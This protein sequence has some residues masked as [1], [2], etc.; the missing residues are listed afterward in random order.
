MDSEG[1]PLDNLAQD[2]LKLVQSL[3][4]KYTKMSEIMAAGPDKKVSQAI[5]GAIERANKRWEFERK[6][7]KKL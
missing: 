7:I 6:I 3:G 1:A 5:Q 2:S 4:L